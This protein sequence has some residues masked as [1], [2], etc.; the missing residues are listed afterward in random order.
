MLSVAAAA[1]ATAAGHDFNRIFTADDL[2]SS[3]NTF[4]VATGVTDG[5]LLEGVRR[6]GPVIFTHS[7]VIRGKT[8]TIRHVN[9]EYQA[10]RWL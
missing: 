2:V 4:F 9:A 6:K 5:G 8:G 10:D 1:R 3:D 7:M